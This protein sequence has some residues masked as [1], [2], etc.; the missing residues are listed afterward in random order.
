MKAG[1]FL[2]RFVIIFAIAFVVNAVVVY[3]WNLILH[4][5]GAF[6]W[7]QSFIIALILGIILSLVKRKK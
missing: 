5:E 3:L 1:Q 4:D 7:G 2:T 6:D